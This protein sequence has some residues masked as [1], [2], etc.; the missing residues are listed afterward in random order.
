[1]HEKEDGGVIL[2]GE[3]HKKLPAGIG[4]CGE[5]SGK[6]SKEHTGTED[7]EMLDQEQC[8]ETQHWKMGQAP[9]IEG[10]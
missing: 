8:L 6:S 10:L 5:S 1:M 7:G 3:Q 2:I 9:V 4:A